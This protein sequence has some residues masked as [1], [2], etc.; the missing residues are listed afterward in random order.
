MVTKML[1]KLDMPRPG[2]HSNSKICVGGDMVV[3]SRRI[4]ALWPYQARCVDGC[5]EAPLRVKAW[6]REAELRRGQAPVLKRCRQ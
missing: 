4:S 5:R 2:R 1:S 3:G 6:A